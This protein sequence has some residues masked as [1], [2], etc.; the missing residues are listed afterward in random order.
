MAIKKWQKIKSK[1][2]HDGW[3]KLDLVSFKM[4]DGKLK[5]FEIID[6]GRVAVSVVGITS[7]EKVVLVKQYRPGPD[8]IFYEF[9]LGLIEKG[10]SPIATAKR[11]FLEETGYTGQFKRVGVQHRSAYSN[12]KV[13]CFAAVNCKKVTSE[14]QLD[15]G[16]FLEVK[17]FPLKTVRQMIKKCQIRNF[18]E[19]YLA[20][21]HLGLL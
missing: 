15:A 12:S 3:K 16:E 2:I 19:G 5:D 21:D 11:E 7:D 18:G 14:L 17:L 4:P 8:K 9:P 20:L 1:N 6:S 13:Y 10:E